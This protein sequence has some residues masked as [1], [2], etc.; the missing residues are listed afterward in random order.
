M[1]KMRKVLSVA[2]AMIMGAAMMIA[3]PAPAKAAT[4]TTYPL[5]SVYTQSTVYS[6]KADGVTIPVVS[7]NGDY[8]YANFS[9]T[10]GAATL[11]VTVTGAAS[12]SSYSISPKK[13][14]LTGT[15]SGNKLTF[16]ISKDE[17]LIVQINGLRRLVIAADP[18]ETDKP[19]SSGT[20]IFNVKSAPYNADSTGTNLTTAAIQSAIDAASSYNGGIVYVPAGVY[21]IGNLQ[22]KSNIKLYL[23][24]G[25]VLRASTVKSDYT[26]HWHKDSINKDVT[27]WLNTPFGATNIKIYGRGTI[28]GNATALSGFANNLL[29][30]IGCSYFTVDGITFRDS[31]SW[32]V[33]PARS[34]DLTFKNMKIFNRFSVGEDDGIDVCESQNVTVINS[35]GIG[36][37]DPYTTKTWAQ[38]TDI[39][40]GWPGSPEIVSNVVFDDC[41][42]WTY[43][44]G[45]K[46]GQGVLQNQ[47]GVTFKNS[48]VYDCAVGIGVHHKYG[49]GAAS[50]ITF[51]NID[52]EKVGNSND[53]H[54]TWLHMEILSGTNGDGPISN[55]TI[56]NINV[57]DK[58]T[59]SAKMLGYSS[60]SMITGVTFDNVRMPGSA[61]AATTLHD[62]NIMTKAF[63]SGITILPIQNPEPIQRTNIARNKTVTAS[64]SSDAAKYPP[65]NVVD[66]NSN[67]RWSSTYADPA[68]ISINLGAPKTID[69]VRLNWEVAYGRAYR[70]EVS[71][72]GS[73]FTSVY[74][75]TAGDGGYDDISFAPTTAQ[76]VRMYGTQRAT[77]Y[78]YSLWEFEVYAPVYTEDLS[79]GS[80]QNWTAVNGTWAVES[81]E[82]SGTHTTDSGL[83]YYNAANFDNFTYTLNSRFIGST[84]GDTNIIFRY[85]DASNY[86]QTYLSKASGYQYLR[87]YKV[88]NGTA[89]QIGNQVAYNAPID[90]NLT[91]TITCNGS[92]ISATVDGKTATATDATFTTGKIGVK[93]NKSHVHFDNIKVY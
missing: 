27:W 60:S 20:G 52:I 3:S 16:T 19:A 82:Y 58:G 32:A 69:G 44:Y 90:S 34:N 24:G 31:A 30:P 26:M 35:I 50:D 74:S 71:N 39:S 56:K 63:Y 91:W 42:S 66:G 68:W 76:Y 54:R 46:V 67:T 87:I 81:G 13:L 64:S 85:Q 84:S 61:A 86:Y 5:P 36:L 33:T 11:E 59:T 8:D 62:M 45:Y 40:R 48:V 15:T 57:R 70:I 75:T 4:I 28:D 38:T 17:Y 47:T 10:G 9:M 41:I 14:N 78:G 22:L 21:K 73:N 25:A 93:V 79:D 43:C 92:N 53:G 1:L 2:L 29:V 88:V 83:A 37:D 51:D 65:S 55:V 23:E 7:Y 72:D 18:A 12:I 6:L 89:T 80:A 49:T 77:S